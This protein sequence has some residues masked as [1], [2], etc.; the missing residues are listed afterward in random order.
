MNIILI[1]GKAHSGKGTVG[2]KIEN[3][4]NNQGKHV[5]RCSLSTYIR[6]I[7][8]ND[9]YWDGIDTLESR[10]FMG[11]VYR[12]GTEFYPYHMARRV[13]ERDIKPYANKNTTVIVESFR[14]LVNYDYFNILLKEG[15]IDEIST[16]RIIRPKFNSIQNE[17]FEKHVSE[18][19]L[20]DFEFDYIVENDGSIEELDNKLKEMFN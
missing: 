6:E 8:K 10:I 4:L 19:D 12:I 20:D 9:F 13:W 2:R 11:E 17:E 3:I 7:A 14:E 15:L 18:S 16:I 5:I 1:S